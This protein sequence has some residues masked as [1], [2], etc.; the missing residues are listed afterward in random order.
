MFKTLP[1]NPEKLS[2]I[3]GGDSRS[4]PLIRRMA[5]KMVAKLQPDF[6]VFDGD[7][8]A[9]AS[10]AQWADWL[11]DWQLTIADGRI[12]P[13]VA[14]MG[15]HEASKDMEKIFNTPNN[16]IYSLDFGD[17]FHLIILNTEAEIYGEQTEWLL[18]DLQN[19]KM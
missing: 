1:E 14:V 19:T 15:N 2:I 5:N 6:V 3:A 4:Y 10:S 12:I 18:N 11:D 8:T 16:S 13:I 7:F 17:L 9:I